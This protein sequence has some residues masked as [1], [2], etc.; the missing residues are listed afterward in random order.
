[1]S[2][3]SMISNFATEWRVAREDAHTRRI[4]A[5]LP[6]EIQKDIG[7]PDAQNIRHTVRNRRAA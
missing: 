2:I 3:Y 6:I 1:M 5:S 4:V 7:W